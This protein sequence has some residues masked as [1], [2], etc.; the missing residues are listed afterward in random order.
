MM[1]FVLVYLLARVLPL[2]FELHLVPE[3]DPNESLVP[4]MW[5]ERER[6][7]HK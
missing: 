2:Y 5:R 6:K 4:W 7:P 3:Y 1:V